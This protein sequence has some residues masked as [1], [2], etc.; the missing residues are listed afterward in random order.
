MR[1]IQAPLLRQKS[2]DVGRCSCFKYKDGRNVGNLRQRLFISLISLEQVVFPSSLS[3]ALRANCILG[4]QHTHYMPHA[5]NFPFICLLVFESITF[6]NAYVLRITKLKNDH[7]SLPPSSTKCG[8]PKF[9][10]STKAFNES[11][12]ERANRGAINFCEELEV[13]PRFCVTLGSVPFI[14]LLNESSLIT[15]LLQQ[16]KAMSVSPFL[17]WVSA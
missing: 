5:A 13:E 9:R 8:R 7:C 17:A 15:L 6:W 4:T 14:F 10:V 12:W 16:L 1:R 3:Q 2:G 11:F